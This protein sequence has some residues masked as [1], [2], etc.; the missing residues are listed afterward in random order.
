MILKHTE[1]DVALNLL[2]F[3][4]FQQDRDQ[5]LSIGLNYEIFLD[6]LL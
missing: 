2:E 3:L 5:F 1:Q 6:F 4:L